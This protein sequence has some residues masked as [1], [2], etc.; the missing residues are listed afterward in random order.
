[1]HCDDFGNYGVHVPTGSTEIVLDTYCWG[2]C[3]NCLNTSAKNI[4]HINEKKLI[5]IYDLLGREVKEEKEKVL[6]YLYD[7][8]SVEKKMKLK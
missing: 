4:H 2:E 7:D 1:M 8:W 6:F 3:S 5:K